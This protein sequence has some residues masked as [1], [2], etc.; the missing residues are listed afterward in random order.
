MNDRTAIAGMAGLLQ[1]RG[2]RFVDFLGYM[3]ERMIEDKV[4]LN[5]LALAYTTLLALVPLTT[6]SVAVFAAFPIGDR[7][8]VQVQDFVFQNFVPA[9][10]EAV[11]A[12]LDQFSG[13]AAKLGGSSFLFLIVTSLLLMASIDRA[14][15]DIW[16]VKRQ[17]R[18]LTKFLV[19]WAVITVGPLLMGLSLALTSY[20]LSLPFLTDAAESIGGTSRLL[21]IAPLLA[22]TLAFTLLYLL[23]PLR[24]VSLRHALAGGVTA[25]LLFELAKRGFGVYLAYFP[26]YEAIYGALAAIPIFLIWLYL[27]WLVTLFGAELTYSLESFRTLGGRPRSSIWRLADVYAVLAMLWQAQREGAASTAETLSASTRFPVEDMMVLLEGLSQANW[28]AVTENGGWV[29]SRDLGVLT[30]GDL[31]NGFELSLPREEDLDELRSMG[32]DALAGR[33]AITG[34]EL[35]RIMAVP[36]AELFQEQA[37]KDD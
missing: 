17:R 19:Y 25:A 33:M 34:P 20:L 28:V 21:R 12:H 15:N 32:Q 35:R 10:G 13:K 6:V 1:A 22:S 8:I 29:L 14:F 23:V 4:L 30:L 27:S 2:R 36:L 37:V 11:Q 24:R 16:R 5:A 31:Y 3:Q 26:T 18:P 9:A 7:T